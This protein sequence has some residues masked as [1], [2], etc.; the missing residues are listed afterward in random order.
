MGA[1]DSNESI[2]DRGDSNES[3]DCSI[4]PMG[5]RTGT[6]DSDESNIDRVT[7]TSRGFES[8]GH[9]GQKGSD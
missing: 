9:G 3:R 5:S 1:M 8:N 2:I 6:M 7:Q 4:D